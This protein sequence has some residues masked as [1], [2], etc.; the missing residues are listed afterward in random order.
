MGGDAQLEMAKHRMIAHDGQRRDAGMPN[1][2]HE[3]RLGTACFAFVLCARGA[4]RRLRR[5]RRPCRAR[6]A[7]VLV[8]R[9]VR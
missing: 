6:L 7:L 3:E 4:R 8:A 5:R 2:E 1:V 9:P